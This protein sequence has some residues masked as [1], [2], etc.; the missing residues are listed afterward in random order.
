MNIK[1]KFDINQ[2]VLI[3]PTKITGSIDGIYIDRTNTEYYVRYFDSG[4]EPKKIYLRENEIE[5]RPER[6]STLGF[7]SQNEK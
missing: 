7:A 4:G 6:E 1:T 2:N 5:P 3:K